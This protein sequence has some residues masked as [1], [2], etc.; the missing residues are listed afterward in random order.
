MT[1]GCS[2][3][4]TIKNYGSIFLVSLSSCPLISCWCLLLADP[5]KSQ[6][7]RELGCFNPYISHFG[8]GAELRRVVNGWSGC[9]W[10]IPKIIHP[11][12]P[13]ASTLAP[14]PQPW[15]P[16]PPQDLDPGL[17]LFFPYH[18]SRWYQAFPWLVMSLVCWLLTYY[19]SRLLESYAKIQLSWQLLL[20]TPDTAFLTHL[21]LLIALIPLSQYPIHQQVLSIPTLK[22]I[23]NLSI[24]SPCHICHPIT[25]NLYTS[26]LSSSNL[27]WTQQPEGPS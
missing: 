21:S 6:R 19:S 24:L 4:H 7:A 17:L 15:Q 12:F 14:S 3:C 27:F 20:S 8:H 23:P 10:K 2:Q 25:P 18:L 16:L 5:I 1:G 26:L 11:S 22:Y 9:K 13:P